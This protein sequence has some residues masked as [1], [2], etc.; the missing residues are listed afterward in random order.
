ML[1]TASV[2]YAAVLALIILA[3]SAGALGAS[4][5][6]H[7]APAFS[8]QVPVQLIST[9]SQSQRKARCRSGAHADESAAAAVEAGAPEAA[10]CLTP[11]SSRRSFHLGVLFSDST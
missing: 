3:P 7:W 2:L 8:I 6:N 11:P 9:P 5:T 10:G 1:G 4:T